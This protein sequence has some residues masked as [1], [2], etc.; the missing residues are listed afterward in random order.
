MGV[1]LL[2]EY[3]V[4]GQ[5]ST[6]WLAE[7]SQCVYLLCY[8]DIPERFGRFVAVK[9]QT[10]DINHL[11]QSDILEAEFVLLDRICSVKMG[12]VHPGKGHV[13]HILKFNGS[14]DVHT[15]L[16]FSVVGPFPVVGPSLSAYLYASG[17]KKVDYMLVSKTAPSGFGLSS[18]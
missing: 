8:I 5:Y 13:V 14:S 12:H 17:S 15:C 3:S 9:V 11:V 2:W 10:I 18:R 7:D 16:T 6:V 4:R 1:M